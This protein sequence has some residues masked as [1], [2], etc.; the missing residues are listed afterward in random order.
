ME[1]DQVQAS[2]PTVPLDWSD[3]GRE[4]LYGTLSWTSHY[5]SAASSSKNEGEE[6]PAKAPGFVCQDKLCF[7]CVE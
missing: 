1:P 3:K 5:M 6:Y 2:A 4:C 7:S